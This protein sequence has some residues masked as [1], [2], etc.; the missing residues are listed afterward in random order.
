MAKGQL[1]VRI[2]GDDSD[3][4]RKLKSAGGALTKFAAVGA[5]A[6]AGVAV[7]SVKKF[8]DFDQAMTN[9]LAIMG[10]VSDEMRGAMSDAAREVA[11]TTVFSAEQAAE[12]YFFLA[13]AG[14]DAAESIEALPKVAAFAQAGNFDMALATDLLTDA[15]SALGLVVDDSAQSLENMA[16]VGD[17]LV[18]ANTLANASVEEFS[19]ALT[20]KA[21]AALNQLNKDVEEGVAVL[22]VYADQGVKGSAAGTQ[23]NAVLEGLTRTAR[24]NA[25]AYD[26]LG[27][28]VF[29][30]DG[31][32]RNMAD[33]VGDLEGA[34]GGM[35]TE[36]QLA[37]LA[38]LGLT[39][40]AR[41]GVV[42]LLGNA[43]AMREY[44]AELR[45]AAG[46]VDEVADKQLQTFW[47]QL[48]LLRDQLIDVALGIGE[49]LMP[50]L[51]RFVELLQEHGPTLERIVEQVFNALGV[52]LDQVVI[53]ALSRLAEWWG[54]HGPDII[55]RVRSFGEIVQTV[56]EAVGGFI[57]RLV[58]WFRTGGTGIT[59]STSEMSEF[60]RETWEQI[61]AVVGS[62]VDAISGFMEFLGRLWEMHGETILGIAERV[63][64]TIQSII[65]GA[66]NVLQGIFET[67]AG[68]F[69]G[70]WS[71]MWGGIKQI[72]SGLWQAVWSIL[73]LAFDG[74]VGLV[75]ILW[76]HVRQQFM[77]GR[78]LV[79][80][81]ARQLVDGFRNRVQTLVTFVRNIPRMILQALGNLGRMLFDAGRSILRG[82]V[83]GIRSMASAPVDAVRNVVANVRNFLPFSPAKEGPFSGSG[84]PELSGVAIGRDITAGLQAEQST[85]ARAMSDL[86]AAAETEARANLSRM[87]PVAVPVT[88]PSTST[89]GDRTHTGPIV[90]E[91]RSGGSQFD[92]LLVEVLRKSISARGGDVQV[93]LGRTRT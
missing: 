50:H 39:R 82:L 8:A 67:F 32:M 28:S 6:V 88:A 86:M 33:I 69:T 25:D 65:G 89:N 47:A 18:K 3:L 11:K 17:V 10:D 16:R 5:A 78:D 45:N 44:E 70:D 73:K 90:L 7:F 54:V 59:E 66:L 46:T 35:S 55:E 64:G 22:A 27:V 72:F 4:T 71:R 20:E 77:A 15:Q 61:Q 74:L 49:R 68:L 48:G 26:S 1:R 42:Q 79:V 80:N 13:S 56:F 23:L 30:A 19:S 53:P 36:Q 37:E 21:G 34:L 84:A 24:T 52:I 43:D 2:V 14:M 31:E 51:M 38:S 93:V 87:A 92:D 9:S 85:V 57:E 76:N 60:L 63:W 75:K 62:A 81:I 40:Q 29:D 83:D 91:I 58:G 12:S 41:D